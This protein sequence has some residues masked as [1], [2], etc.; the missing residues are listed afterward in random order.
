M[1]PSAFNSHNVLL[2]C[3]C[4]SGHPAL[5]GEGEPL[6]D[7]HGCV[8]G[9]GGTMPV[10]RGQLIKDNEYI[11]LQRQKCSAQAGTSR[12]GLFYSSSLYLSTPKL[13]LT[14]GCLACS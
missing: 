7:L 6:T 12:D 2:S 5:T 11:I 1:Y 3:D 9:L 13:F 10:M 4:L 14:D 8:L